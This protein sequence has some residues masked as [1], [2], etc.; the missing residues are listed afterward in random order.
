MSKEVKI[1]VIGGGS[2]YTPFLVQNL[3]ERKDEFTVSELWL[4]DIKEQEHRLNIVFDFSQALVKKSHENIKLFKSINRKEALIDADFVITQMNVGMHEQNL[5]D[6]KI[7]YENH[8][9]ANEFFGVGSV[10]KALRTMPLMYQIIDEMNEECEHAWMINL[11]QPMGLISEAVIRYA[12]FDKYI[13]ISHVPLDMQTCFSNILETKPNQLITYVAGL[14]PISFM[15][16]VFCNQKDRYKDLI[17]TIVRQEAMC[18]WSKELLRD[19][20]VF[21]SPDLKYVYKQK[22]VLDDFV[23]NFENHQTDT[24]LNI[25][26]EAQLFEHYKKLD[27]DS[28]MALLKT[29]TGIEQSI[30]A[31]TL[32]SS[33]IQDKRDYQIVNTINNGHIADLPESSAIEITSRITKDGP[34][35]IHIFRISNQVKGLLQ[36]IKSFEELIADAIYEKDLNKVLLA[37]K[38]HPLMYDNE[39]IK[40]SFD[41]FI[42][43]N[44]SYLTYYK[45]GK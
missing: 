45:K 24:L 18:F 1:V 14:S 40:T 4:V 35:P 41:K 9:Y 13:G 33:M 22:N 20:E 31:V 5:M 25:K 7:C 23:F 38:V 43:L 37:L 12:E 27:I 10:F 15:T 39:D 19:L 2:S 17:E 30:K 8:M 16:N 32:I 6:E 3:L 42:E 21:P 36:H 44:E 11:T 34:M 28:A 26:I 29:R